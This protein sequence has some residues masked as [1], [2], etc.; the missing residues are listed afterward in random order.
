MDDLIN[1]FLNVITTW[2]Q[3]G[4]IAGLVVVVNLLTNLTKLG[5]FAKYVPAVA[6]PWVALGLGVAAGF[7]SALAAGKSLAQAVVAG[8][9]I[10]LS[11][12]GTHEVVQSSKVVAPKAMRKLKRVPPAAFILIGLSFGTTTIFLA[13]CIRGECAEPAHAG[14]LKCVVINGIVDCT[15]PELQSTIEAFIPIAT[16]YLEKLVQPDSSVDWDAFADRLAASG[17]ADAMCIFERVAASFLKLWPMLAKVSPDVPHVD[18]EL[19]R[20]L[21]HEARVKRF[22]NYQVKTKDGVQ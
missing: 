10:G 5:A 4:I 14:E 6:R 16:G 18:I 13:G 7:L 12:I 20:T 9:L 1:Q 15:K 21:A 8:L 22:G 17:R 3:A 19:N 2:Q 11:S